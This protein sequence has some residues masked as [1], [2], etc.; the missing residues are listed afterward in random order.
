M[1]LGILMIELGF[2]LAY[3]SGGSAQW[4]G[5]AVNG[6]AALLLIPVSLLFFQEQFS[7]HKILGIVLTLSGMYFLVKK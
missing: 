1:A 7:W 5:V 2:L 3:Q 6:A 4:S